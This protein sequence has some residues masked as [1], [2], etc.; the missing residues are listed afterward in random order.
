MFAG[1]DGDSLEGYCAEIDECDTGDH[2]CDAEDTCDKL[3][4]SWNYTCNEGYEVSDADG[5]CDDVDEC[6]HMFYQFLNNCDFWNG[7]CVNKTRRLRCRCNDGFFEANMME[8]IVPIG[9]NIKS[10]MAM[11]TLVMLLFVLMT[12][13]VYFLMK[14]KEKVA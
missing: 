1:C 6:D 2:G 13:V 5:D 11:I 12:S 3:P 14:P 7:Y 9:T 8:P 4:G 10:K